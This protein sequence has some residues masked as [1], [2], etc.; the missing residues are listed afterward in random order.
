MKSGRERFGFTLI[1]L[2]VVVTIIGILATMLMPALSRAQ[3]AAR[4]MSCASNLRQIFLTLT[5]YA[6]EW[7]GRFPPGDNNIVITDVRAP[8]YPIFTRN[9]YMMDANAIFP[10]YMNDL[11]V[12]ACPSDAE[13]RNKESLFKD[14]TFE[15]E[16]R[17]PVVGTD[18]L[19]D[20]YDLSIVDARATVRYDADC[21]FSM[22][23]TYLP[24]AVY[25]DMQAFALFSMLDDMM[26]G[27]DYT[28]GA[29]TY[30]YPPDMS[31]FM[32][33]DIQLPWEFA[34]M[35]TGDGDTIFRLRDGVERFF[36]TDINNPGRS[37]V[38]ASQ[39]PIMFDTVRADLLDFSH[40]PAGGNILY[41]DGHVE[42]VKYPDRRGRIPYTRFFV[43]MFDTIKAFNIPPW[44]Y[45]S[46]WEYEPRWLYF[47]A[48]YDWLGD[49]YGWR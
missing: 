13:Y 46:D 36:I 8:V 14:I 18:P 20:G 3:E 48:E 42:F 43:D 40:A 27:T 19:L 1:E 26:F 24:Y 31:G 15:R 4:R 28:V 17:A 35:G 30:Y 9:N 22:S 21:L 16:Y 38:S 49:G 37:A 6:S 29:S 34:F 11:L 2:M 5:M 45:G 10:E 41:M 25:T 32:D 33:E 7:D 44:C 12:F 47:P 39:L 23:Y